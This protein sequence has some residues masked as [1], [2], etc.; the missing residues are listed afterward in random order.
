MPAATF[1]PTVPRLTTVP[2]VMYSQQWSPAPSTTAS[3]REALARAPVDEE[4]AAG[5]AVQARVA[6]QRGLAAGEAGARRRQDD[7]LT[8]SHTLTHV[9]IRLTRQVEL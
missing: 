4:A 9:V 7:D 6:H 2:P 5:R 8:A 3:D 1:L